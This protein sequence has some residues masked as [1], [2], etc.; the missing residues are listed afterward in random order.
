M[1]VTVT[2]LSVTPTWAN[3]RL[4]LEGSVSVRESVALRI[5]GCGDDTSVVFKLSS[6]NGRVDYAKF[7]NAEGDAWTEDAGDLTGTLNLNTS[8]LVAAFAPWG[9]D[10]RISLVC[11]VAS[12]TNSNLYAKG[13]IQIGN[14]MEDTDDPVAYSTPLADAIDELTEAFEA[15]THDGTDAPK[16]AHSDLE[17]I[18]VNTHD[19]IDAALTSHAASIVT[20]TSGVATN[21]SN[22][23][24]N[25]L[26]ISNLDAATVQYTDFAEVDALATGTTTTKMLREKLN[27]ILAILKG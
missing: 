21:A 27:E 17:E 7:P 16:V 15:H 13:C 24:A 14:W 18:G 3:K 20:L 11:T 5:V 22:I 1:S 25:A 9:P 6:E 23:A 10:D 2:A 19:Q 8:L 12:A 26:A 4:T